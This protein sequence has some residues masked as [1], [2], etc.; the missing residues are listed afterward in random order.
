MLEFGTLISFVGRWLGKVIGKEADKHLDNARAERS[1]KD[2]LRQYKDRFKKE[3]RTISIYRPSPTSIEK[4]FVEPKIIK[5]SALSAS[6]LIS[7]DAHKSVFTSDTISSDA[8][9]KEMSKIARVAASDLQKIYDENR[10]EVRNVLGS[11]KSYIILGAAGGGKSTLISYLAYKNMSLFPDRIPIFVNSAKMRNAN[12]KASIDEIGKELN[13]EHSLL[14][15]SG[16]L[17]IIYIDGLDELPRTEMKKICDEIRTLA[18]SYEN[19]IINVS[20]REAA[21]DNELSTFISLTVLPF[22]QAQMRSFI[23]RWPFNDRALSKN[24]Q[25]ELEKNTRL[26]AFAS[27]PILLVLLCGSYGRYKTVEK[28]LAAI[29]DQC[30]ETLLWSWDADRSIPSRE[31]FEG[32]DL[33][34]RR[35]MHEFLAFRVHSTGERYVDART[36]ER[37]VIEYAKKTGIT[38]LDGKS[39]LVNISAQ[40]GLLEKVSENLYCFRHLGIQEFLA[41]CW[42]SQES[43][44]QEFITAEKIKAPWWREVFAFCAGKSSDAT[45]FFCAIRD[46]EDVP[47]IERYS[48]LAHCMRTDPILDAEVRQKIVG[49]ILS[50]YHNG[51]QQHFEGAKKMIVGIEDAWTRPVIQRSIS[52]DLPDH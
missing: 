30:V 46:N 29:Y 7:P 13:L 44:W 16:G 31:L 27:Q 52:G 12:I 22:D 23:A 2:L 19:L 4:G 39:I 45:D 20:C 9:N 38:D 35:W 49:V 15:E 18:S 40:N 37:Y 28:R 21:Y 3:R 34:K 25:Y 10:I 1:N 8:L 47:S 41:G 26:F 51:D 42:I 32:F 33:L 24:L 36:L 5:T 50:W 48:L 14:E 6:S 11:P 17:L 43:R